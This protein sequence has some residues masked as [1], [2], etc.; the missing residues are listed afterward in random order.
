MFT[1]VYLCLPMFT[2]VYS[3]MFTYVDTCLLVFTYVYTCLPMF[4]PVYSCLLMFTCVYLCLRLLKPIH[5]LQKVLESG[6]PLLHRMSHIVSI[7]LQM[8]ITKYTGPYTLFGAVMN[9]LPVAQA[10]QLKA[11]LRVFYHCLGKHNLPT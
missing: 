9:I 2:I 7:N 11:D 1:T 8:E 5:A 4:T 3:C 6:E 10:D